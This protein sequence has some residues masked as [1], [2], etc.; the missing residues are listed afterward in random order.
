MWHL[1]VSNRK[2]QA[3]WYIKHAASCLHYFQHLQRLWRWALWFSWNHFLISAHS[4]KRSLHEE[5]WHAG[6]IRLR[7]RHFL[8][9]LNHDYMNLNSM[10]KLMKK[11]LSSSTTGCEIIHQRMFLI[12]LYFRNQE[13][14]SAVGTTKHFSSEN[15]TRSR[16]W[17]DIQLG[18][19][20]QQ[21]VYSQH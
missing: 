16:S 12:I 4:R 8:L 6:G 19:A 5:T 18:S 21:N 11:K 20:L 13:T 10:L 3:S 1:I 17:W 7:H 14:Y 15:T 2:K 9:C